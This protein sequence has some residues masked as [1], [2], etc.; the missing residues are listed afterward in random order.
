MT[1]HRTHLL[2]RK[3]RGATTNRSGRFES[4][5]REAF[6]DG[7]GAIDDDLEPL[8]TEIGIDSSTSLR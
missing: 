6:D 4:H 2:Q 1:Q 3:G 7:W 5:T 8:D